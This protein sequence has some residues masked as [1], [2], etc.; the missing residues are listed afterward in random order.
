[1]YPDFAEFAAMQRMDL[2]QRFR[3]TS[4]Y[5][6]AAG[7]EIMIEIETGKVLLSCCRPLARWMM[8]VTSKSS[9]N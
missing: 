4:F 1:M 3:R 9:L 7:D 2:C 6:M 8:R 5:G